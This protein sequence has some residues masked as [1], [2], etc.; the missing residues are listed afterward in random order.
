[1]RRLLLLQLACAGAGSCA[2]PP[3]V[4][5]ILVVDEGADL[6]TDEVKS[7]LVRIGQDEVAVLA[8][9]E[10]QQTI[11]L[12]DPPAGQTEILVFACEGNATCTAASAAFAGCTVTTLAPSP[13]PVT[14][15]VSLFD[16]N[17]QEPQCQAFIDG[18]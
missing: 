6:A 15:S 13:D 9:R 2:A 10:E 17:A 5:V 18:E 3:A 8:A 7:L 1:M 4:V 14:V 12:V 16:I 11:E